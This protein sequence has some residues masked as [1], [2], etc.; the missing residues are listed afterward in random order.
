MGIWRPVR[1]GESCEAWR[2]FEVIVC[3]NDWK[4]EPTLAAVSTAPAR[5]R[6]SELLGAGAGA[7]LTVVPWCQ[8]EK[9]SAGKRPGARCAGKMRIK[10][11]KRA[12]W[13]KG[14]AER[15]RDQD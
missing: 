4:K 6:N 8:R 3:Q 9:G 15:E 11:L 10:V 2:S 12:L 13:V 14:G 1:Y 5:N 7:C